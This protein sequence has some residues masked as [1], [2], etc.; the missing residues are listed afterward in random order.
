MVARL[1]GHAE[2]RI[3]DKGRL[4]MPSVFRKTLEAAYGG[5]LFITALTDD[6]LQI[7]PLQVW[8]EIET[9]VAKL[10]AMNPAKRR[11]MT[12]VNRLGSEVDMDGQGRVSLKSNQRKLVG[13]EDDIILI[14]CS[15]HIELWPGAQIEALDGNDAFSQDDFENLGI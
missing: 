13:I 10:G 6:C 12:R 11:F 5:T 2:A 15:D 8:E 4:K 7:Y 1:R 14:G 3:D 9:K